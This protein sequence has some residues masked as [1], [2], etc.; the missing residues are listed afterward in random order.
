MFKH[1]VK[2]LVMNLSYVNLGKPVLQATGQQQ[3]SCF[4]L[5][6]QLALSICNS[7]STWKEEGEEVQVLCPL[8]GVWKR[9]RIQVSSSL[10][11]RWRNS[12]ILCLLFIA[13]NLRMRVV[14]L[15]ESFKPG[16]DFNSGFSR[17]FNLSFQMFMYLFFLIPLWTG[18]VSSTSFTIL[19]CLCIPNSTHRSLRTCVL[20]HL[21]QI[22]K[23]LQVT[24]R[25]EY[26]SFFYIQRKIFV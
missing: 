1:I 5:F 13:T 17:C 24:E 21:C 20:L 23:E 4:Q 25:Q 22:C 14:L 19:K 3:V 9:F 18:F 15:E 7:S 16:T 11:G 26:F 2:Y 10:S 8:M 12:C 6:C